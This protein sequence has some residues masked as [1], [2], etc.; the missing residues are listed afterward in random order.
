MAI[1]SISRDWGFDPSIV[2][3]TAT[4]TLAE[5]GTSGYLASQLTNIES[6]NAGPFEWVVSD[7]VLVY[8]SDG[9]G[10]FTISA[11]LADLTPFAIVTGVTT[12]VVVGDFAVFDSTGGNIGDSGFLPSDPA[13]TRVVM[14]GSAVQSGYIAHFVDTTGTIDDTAA[15][16]IN[17]G[18]IQSGKDSVVGGII[19]YPAGASSG[20]LRLTPVNNAG[21]FNVTI[22]NASHG[23]S[24]VYS[25]PDVGAATGQLL[26]KTAALVDGNLIQ[27]SGTA[28]KV[29]DSGLSAAAQLSV[30]SVP[31][32][33]AQWN[34]MYAA[35]FLLIAAPGANK[36]IVVSQIQLIMTYVSANYAAGGVVAAQY[37]STANG[38]G[39]AASTTLAAADIQAAASSTFLMS[40][41]S[42]TGTVLPFTTTVNKALY[43]SNKSGAFT[44]GDSTWVV[45][46]FYRIVAT[47]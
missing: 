7:M 11:D 23:Q 4:N 39:V 19:T 26:N 30:V 21:A 41:A 3:I 22:S 36:L 42:G 16:V 13:K 38:L 6:I 10:F 18:P 29:V 2:R 1:T 45:K 9:W 24:T 46:V 5:V 40:A 27:A 31:M 28:G 35:P 15:T 17:D 14:A 34:G 37:D 44:T 47:A 32:T 33:A 12:P 20:T 8:A 43:L 25:I